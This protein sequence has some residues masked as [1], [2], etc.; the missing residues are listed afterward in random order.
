MSLRIKGNNGGDGFTWLGSWCLRFCG[1]VFLHAAIS[2]GFPFHGWDF[3]WEQVR[4]GVLAMAAIL[5]SCACNCVL[6]INAL[7]DSG[8]VERV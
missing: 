8:A 4:E 7:L 5:Q 2:E 6:L 3:R 1:R